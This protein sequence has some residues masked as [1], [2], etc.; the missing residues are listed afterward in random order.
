M[1]IYTNDHTDRIPNSRPTRCPLNATIS[2]PVITPRFNPAESHL[3]QPKPSVRL[4]RSL[5]SHHRRWRTTSTSILVLL[6]DLVLRFRGATESALAGGL[7]G[8][9]AAHAGAVA[10]LTTGR[11]LAAGLVAAGVDGASD[12]A[13]LVL[14]SVGFC[15]VD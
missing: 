2:S 9:L 5:L 3:S 1:T 4:A 11:L 15:G 13:H 7:G 8:R 12:G 14:V 10:T 6:V